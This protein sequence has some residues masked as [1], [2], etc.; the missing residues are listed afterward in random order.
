MGCLGKGCLILSCFIVFLIIAG[1]IGLYFGFKTHSAVLRS[2]LWA[3][4]TH[5]LSQESSPV[6]Q[7]E[8]TQENVET[9]KQKWQNFEKTRDQ[10]AHIEL[11]ADDL[12]NLIANNRHARG[13]VFVEIEGNRLR[14]QTSVPLGEYISGGRYYLNGD[15]VIQSDGP[16]TL[17]SPRLS[18]ITVNNEP[19]PADVLD[20]KYRSR[21][22]REY[23]GDYRAT[24]GDGT[25]EIRDGRV[26]ID[27]R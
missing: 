22:L 21:Q 24:Y 16:Q 4:K 2:V 27:R 13:K 25:I 15:I 10:P 1:A 12:N 6:P 19:I 17:G 3:K 23:L 26:I 5:V 9:A 18:S 20:W 7:F 14:I 8:T 11:T